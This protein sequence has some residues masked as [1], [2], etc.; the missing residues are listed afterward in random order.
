VPVRTVSVRL[1]AEIAGYVTSMRE[2]AQATKA[3]GAE[4]NTL[5]VTQKSKFDDITKK[6]LIAGAAI[7]SFG[8]AAIAAGVQFDR[9]MS[10]VNATMDKT[11]L[12]TKEAAAQ[13]GNLRTAAIAAGKDTVFSATDAAKAEAELTKAG[14]GAADILGGG[15][16]GSLALASAGTLDLGEAA[17]DSAQAMNEFGLKGAA[18]PHIADVL[19]AAANT[20]ATDVGKM[21]QSL[22]QA[23]LVAHQTGLTLE[24]T[25]GTL[26]AFAQDGLAGSDAGTSLKTMLQQLQ[27]PSQVTADLMKKLGINAYN[28]SGN[29]IGITNLA[30]QL[31]DKLGPLTQAERDNALAQIFGNDAVRAAN[32]LYENG[33]DGLQKWIDGVNQ[34][35]AA[36]D[37]AR[38]KMDNLSGDLEQ[39]KGSLETV[40]IESSGG[41]RDGLRGL[42]QTATGT[43]NAFADLPDWLQQ[44]AVWLSAIGGGSLVAVTG[45]V[46]ARG[47][48]KDFRSA[49]SEMGPA[50]DKAS[51][52]FGAV[53]KWGGIATIAATAGFGLYAL[54]K[55]LHASAQPVQLD[56]DKLTDS[57]SKF[58]QESRVTGELKTLFGGNDLDAFTKRVAEY[59]RLLA[60]VTA[61]QGTPTGV[62]TGEQRSQQQAQALSDQKPITAFQQDIAATDAAFA[63]MVRN[64]Q[65][66]QA[67]ADMNLFQDA[68]IKGGMSLQEFNAQFPQ[69]NQLAQDAALQSHAVAQ[70][71]GSMTEQATLMSGSL[72]EA[73]KQAGSLLDVEN[74]L[75]GANISMIQATDA[76]EA[77]YDAAS[78]AVKKNGETANKN[79]TELLAT[80]DAG[81]ANREALLGIVDAATKASQA[82]LDQT[83]SL[84]KAN[85]VI[86][87]ARAQ[88]IAMA[89]KMGLSEDAAGKLADSLLKLP[90]VNPK[91]NVVIAEAEKNVERIRTEIDK[92]H[93]K[94]VDIKIR[95]GDINRG[96][97]TAA[98]NRWGGVYT[99]AAT[100][101]ISAATYRPSNPA[102]YAFAE[103]QTGGEAFVPKYG[104][105]ARSTQIIDTAARW[106]G[107]RFVSN[108]GNGWGG[109]GGSTYAPTSH[110]TVNARTADFSTLELMAIQARVDAEHRVGFPQ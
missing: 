11:G 98:A 69:Y 70:G 81:R 92:I 88:F 15:L 48:V 29:F 26:A 47:A 44:T 91:V 54:F 8:V 34:T 17:T 68:A 110:I 75:H 52:V 24:D 106:Y 42:T 50:G 40:A 63:N 1:A 72:A 104:N 55:N 79:H 25:A 38:A 7:A 108:V 82:T 97:T 12:T 84:D 95:T 13:L 35:G 73:V 41:A 89:E 62:V 36:S 61:F 10:E 101:L 96:G 93:G 71:F 74:K 90:D 102:L 94:T 80:T 60:E 16:R 87:T 86:T 27:A 46:K 76:L 56:V 39:L 19:A 33:K 21:A 20:S 77:S 100:G 107:G 18:I 49:L 37:T 23:G 9:Q 103:P 67:A 14:I 66:T 32:V 31:K 64:G 43:V 30:Q 65:A 57:L 5:S 78:A 99:H 51:K 58:A 2:A 3:F 85:A 28:A 59:K 4:L 83:G 109:G 6:G 45:F 22:N 53:S 105:Y